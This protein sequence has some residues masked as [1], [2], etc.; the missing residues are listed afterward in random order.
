MKLVKLKVGEFTKQVTEAE[1]CKIH[2]DNLIINIKE[3]LN[4]R[5]QMRRR[6][7]SLYK[8]KTLSL[9]QFAILEK[10]IKIE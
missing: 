2:Q 6:S 8:R 10:I 5:K 9:L 3:T 4:G 7:C 1:K